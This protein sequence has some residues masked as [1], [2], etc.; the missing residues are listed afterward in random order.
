M[1][2]ACAGQLT[3]ISVSIPLSRWPST[4]QY[5]SYVPDCN[6]TGSDAESPGARLL[7][8]CSSMP[9]PSIFS[10][11]VVPPSFWAVNVYVPGL[12]VDCESSRL[13]SVS[14]TVTA[15]PVAAGE[16]AEVDA[17]GEVGGGVLPADPS[18][19]PPPHAASIV[20]A[21]ST[22]PAR[23]RECRTVMISPFG[24]RAASC[25]SRT[26]S[27]TP[28]HAD[29]AT[30]VQVVN[31]RRSN[32]RSARQHQNPGSRSIAAWATKLSTLNLVR[33]H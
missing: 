32:Q 18:E 16:D 15:V 4:G 21:P 12:N 5:S 9:G 8:C 33:P 17:D 26:Q 22:A 31:G 14:L 19:E 10:A 2:D 25:G 30:P 1:R 3:V 24:K 28:W 29:E 20:R 11:C 13:Y 7:V 27:A 23:A 6:V